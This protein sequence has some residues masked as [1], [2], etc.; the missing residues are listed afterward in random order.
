MTEL[1]ASR[2]P[3]RHTAK[4][5][6]EWRERWAGIDPDE[7]LRTQPFG[8]TEDGL[9]DLRG[10]RLCP[11]DAR[12][13]K[14]LNHAVFKSCDFTAGSLAETVAEHSV[15]QDCVFDYADMNDFGDYGCTFINCRF[16]RCE[17]QVGAIGFDYNTSKKDEYQSRYINCHFENIK[18]AKT[19]I[20]DPQFVNCVFVFKKLSGV[21]F[22]CSGFVNCRF[23]GAFQD[24]TFRGKYSDEKDTARKGVPELAGFTEVSFEKAALQWIDVRAEFPFR[25]VRMPA[26]GSAFI[27]DMPKLCQEQQVIAGQLSD[28]RSQEILANYLDVG[29]L[30]ID[31]QPQD[32]ISRYDLFECCEK[33]EEALVGPI[34]DLL[35]QSYEIST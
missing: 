22:G 26:D 25:S 11:P 1:S 29:C 18:L 24:L 17:W 28:Q 13:K 12:R 23:E 19:S 31:T 3:K 27:A 9:F 32:I 14:S 2:P 4:Q 35:K 34:Y 16:Y 6:T 10:L 15:F 8:R 20:G 33:G 5:F 7:A 21:D 30:R